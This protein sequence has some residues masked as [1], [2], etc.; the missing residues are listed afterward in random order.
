VP[1]TPSEN[2]ELSADERFA[3][4]LG[5]TGDAGAY[6]PSD[7]VAITPTP[8]ADAL[9]SWLAA[10]SLEP[11]RR[12]VARYRWI[13]LSVSGRVEQLR[14]S[15]W[16]T[17]FERGSVRVRSRDTPGDCDTF[18]FGQLLGLPLTLSL[19]PSLAAP[20][21]VDL[22][23]R[24]SPRENPKRSARRILARRLIM[25]EACLW[26]FAAAE[27]GPSPTLPFATRIRALRWWWEPEPEPE[28]GRQP[29]ETLCL[30]CGWVMLTRVKRSGP[31][32]CD[33]CVKDKTLERKNAIAPADRGTWWL[34]CSAAGCSEPFVGRP[35]ARRCLAHRLAGIAP[36]KRPAR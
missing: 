29:A 32:F 24:L 3:S 31:P 4:V 6:G 13:G 34:R 33:H 12:F 2:R 15:L 27:D 23:N 16:G 18:A 10:A 28:P 36:S 1:T 11:L 22:A 14:P 35:Q 25:Q 17:R 9:A 5:L 20:L 8:E 30:R 26:D 19:A 21:G 7:L